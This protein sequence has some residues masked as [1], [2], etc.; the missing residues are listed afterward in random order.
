MVYGLLEKSLDILLEQWLAV[1]LR[2]CHPRRSR[3]S[4]AAIAA[5]LA[6]A[7]PE[8]AVSF[9]Q[10]FVGAAVSEAPKALQGSW[11]SDRLCLFALE[12]T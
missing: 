4:A 3:S 7:L 1:C 12:A 9:P 2:L 11:T 8:K 5:R 10:S 6:L